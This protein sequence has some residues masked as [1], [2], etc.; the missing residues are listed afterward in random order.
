VVGRLHEKAR[1]AR[2][3]LLTDACH[4]LGATDLLTAHHREDQAETVLMRLAKGSGVEGLAGIAAC[5][6]R[7]GIRILR[8]F[9]PLSKDRLM[10][11][12]DAASL[13]C[14]ADPSNHSAR[15]A[16]GRLRQILPLLA[17]EGMTVDNLTLLAA[18]AAEANEA[19]DFYAKKLLQDAAVFD[20]GGIVRIDGEKWR[21]Q[22]RD[23]AL[24]ALSTCLRYIYRGDY[25][26]ERPSV[27]ALLDAIFYAPRPTARSL[28]GCL[29]SLTAHQTLIL[30]EPAAVTEILPVQPGQTLLWD[31]R[32][33]VTIPAE[34]TADSVIRALGNP[35]H[36]LIDRL[37]PGLRRLLPQGRA[38]ATLPAL[39]RHGVLIAIPSFDANAD[40]HLEQIAIR[41]M[42]FSQQPFA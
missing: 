17:A 12:C 39:W 34:V 11:T 25:P 36:S 33:Q 31:Q 37:A 13:A 38:R 26:P 32:W 35:P 15:F 18:R 27:A 8:P 4:R 10:A 24:R 22:P 42:A 5:A 20:P 7:D 29:V 16:R 3:R 19:L 41:L 6:I 28:H 30:R 21:F 40:F 1:Q 23:T 14:V 9:L 2:Y